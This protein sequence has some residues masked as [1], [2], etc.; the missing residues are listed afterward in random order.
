MNNCK[1]CGNCCRKFEAVIDQENPVNAKA[2]A[3]I[4]KVFAEGS[5][6][7][8]LS[9]YE[10]IKIRIEGPC[11]YLTPENS[12][13]IYKDRPEICKTFYCEKSLNTSE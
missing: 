7:M 3:A 1:K 10:K 2:V 4:K 11:R 8:I 12:C 5:M 6:K 13:A 9:R